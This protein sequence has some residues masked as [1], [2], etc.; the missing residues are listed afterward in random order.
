MDLSRCPGEQPPWRAT[1]VA[2][3]QSLLVVSRAGNASLKWP[4][5]QISP[6]RGPRQ[7]L[8]RDG[9][10]Y[11]PSGYEGYIR[12]SSEP[13]EER[14]MYQYRTNAA[15]MTPPTWRLW[16]SRGDAR[17]RAHSTVYTGDR[18]TL[19]GRHTV[20]RRVCLWWEHSKPKGPK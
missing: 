5:C 4:G 17:G 1:H 20:G 10:S 11:P 15:V 13:P 7:V 2:A 9:R 8:G 19:C 18:A 14:A 6:Q 16:S 3:R 12:F